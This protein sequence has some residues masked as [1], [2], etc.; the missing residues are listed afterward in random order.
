MLYFLELVLSASLLVPFAATQTNNFTIIGYYTESGSQFLSPENVPFSKLSHV[1]Y[2]FAIV[3]D[4]YRPV[5]TAE[6]EALIPSLVAKAHQEGVKVS[7]SVGGYTGSVHFSEM[8][9]RIDRR[10]IFT[11]ALTS[12]ILQYD[13][14]GI[15]IVWQYPGRKSISCNP[16]DKANDAKNLLILLREIRLA[17][18]VAFLLSPKLLTLGVRVEPF[19][20]N[21]TPMT[22]VSEFAKVVDF[23]SVMAYDINVASSAT[24]GPNSPFDFT[25]VKGVQNSFKQAI[26]SWINAKIP[27]SQLVVGFP[28][29]G[30][31]STATVDMSQDPTNMYV[32][33][34]N[35]IPMGDQDDEVSFEPCPGSIE[36]YS[37][38][39]KYRNLRSQ[40]LLTSPTTA[41]NGW[42]RYWD[43]ASQ[44]PWLYNPATSVFISYDDVESFQIKMNYG[45]QIGV[46]GA[47]I[48][49]LHQ[50][51]DDELL[52]ILVDGL[53][54]LNL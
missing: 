5:L 24:T 2:A 33:K 13:L 28:F 11:T 47:M 25:P 21:D 27:K 9:S 34:S 46:R 30:R 52:N 4:N 36:T 42:T 39:W 51:T 26:N 16:V 43:S 53:I 19:D 54:Q 49:A 41:G 12:L 6:A 23:I 17:F 32:S 3:G 22:D 48:W 35:V 14:D 15:D 40:G 50:D 44:T 29:Y 7:L 38:I 45:Q 1:N 20:V 37:G 31:S 8:V 10:L 18:N